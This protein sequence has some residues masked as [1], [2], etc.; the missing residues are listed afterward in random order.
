[1]RTTFCLQGIQVLLTHHKTNTSTPARIPTQM[2]KKMTM[3][4]SR[5]ARRLYGNESI[6]VALLLHPH[7]LVARGLRLLVA[8]SATTQRLPYPPTVSDM[9]PLSCAQHQPK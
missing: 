3:K 1:M 2:M 5:Y 4:C 9:V 7:H 8:Q 6:Q